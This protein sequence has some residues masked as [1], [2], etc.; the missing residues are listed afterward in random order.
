MNQGAHELQHIKKLAH[1]KGLFNEEKGTLRLLSLMG[2]LKIHFARV[3][4]RFI[5]IIG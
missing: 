2:L 3:F 5:G 4:I 1:F